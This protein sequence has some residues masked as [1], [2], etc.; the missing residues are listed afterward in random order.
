MEPRT[1]Y[2]FTF[3]YLNLQAQTTEWIFSVMMTVFIHLFI[4]LTCNFSL[5]LME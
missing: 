3:Y 5:Y 4:Y 1:V 2:H